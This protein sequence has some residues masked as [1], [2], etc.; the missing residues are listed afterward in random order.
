[1]TESKPLAQSTMEL[2]GKLMAV[3]PQDNVDTLEESIRVRV[4]DKDLKLS[5]LLVRH[6][7]PLL[8]WS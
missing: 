5:L 7:L 2:N 1:M 8:R 6:L 3:F 4:Q